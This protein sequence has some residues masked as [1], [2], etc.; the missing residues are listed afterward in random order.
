MSIITGELPQ[1]VE[2]EGRRYGVYTDFRDWLGFFDSA[3]KR[4][5]AGML[6]IYRELPPKIETAIELAVR[7]GNKGA[8]P[9]GGGGKKRVLDYET[10]AQLIYAAFMG[11]YGIDLCEARLHWYKFC[12]LMAGLGEE[13]RIVKIMGIRGTEAGKISD[14]GKRRELRELQRQY[15]LID[16][17]SVKER[18][19][20][21]SLCF[22]EFY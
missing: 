15:A 21:L 10:D 8:L 14:A 7:F 22:G 19:K 4:D 20:D 11:E 9:Y 13:R 6:K 16:R 12:A 2:F 1:W 18:D 5:I 3:E 17:R